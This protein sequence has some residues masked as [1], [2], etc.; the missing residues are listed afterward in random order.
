MMERKQKERF[1]WLASK[2]KC[3]QAKHL[4]KLPLLIQTNIFLY[5]E[6]TIHFRYRNTLKLAEQQ[7]VTFSPILN[8]VAATFHHILSKYPH[9]R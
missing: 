7:S 9:N 6:L 1:T 4:D 3:G 8:P 2:N 5:F